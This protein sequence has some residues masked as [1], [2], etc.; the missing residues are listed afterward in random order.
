[1][2]TASGRFA[3]GARPN[4]PRRSPRPD[5]TPWLDRSCTLRGLRHCPGRALRRGSAEGDTTRLAGSA[6]TLAFPRRPSRVLWH[7]SGSELHHPLLR[8][9]RGRCASCQNCILFPQAQRLPSFDVFDAIAKS[10]E[11]TL[12]V[13]RIT[14]E[15]PKQRFKVIEEAFKKQFG[16]APDHFVRSPG[17]DCDS[18][19]S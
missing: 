12:F 6:R 1:M 8:V 14:A 17:E 5:P 19:A 13:S 3:R 10:Y 2:K 9:R 18:C 11:W 7:V 15:A 4:R 16:A